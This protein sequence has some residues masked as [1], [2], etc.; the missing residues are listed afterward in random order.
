[1]LN[2]IK[3]QGTLHTDF[4]DFAVTGKL[5]GNNLTCQRKAVINAFILNK[6]PWMR[7]KV[8]GI[9]IGR[10]AHDQIARIRTYPY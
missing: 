2:V 4:D 10:C 5:P 1:M 6:L 8:E 7:R 3:Y 9:Q